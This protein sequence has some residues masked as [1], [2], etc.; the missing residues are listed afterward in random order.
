M[1]IPSRTRISDTLQIWAALRRRP[2]SPRQRLL[3]TLGNLMMFA[4]L[5]LLLYVGG[6]YV[7]NDYQR[8]AA[9]GDND[10]EVPRT[11]I[12]ASVP[13]VAPQLAQVAPKSTTTAQSSTSAPVASSLPQL[14][15]ISSAM[16]SAAQVAHV[17]TVERV[18]IPSIALDSKV[19]EVG[20]S[21]QKID[22]KLAAV[23][24]VAEY[25]IGQHH[26]SANPG[27]G[28]NIVLAGHVGGYGHVF[29]DLFYVHPGEQVIVYSAG[30]EFLYVVQERL[31]VEEDDAPLAQRIENTKLI[32]PTDHEQI[33]MITC[34]P[35]KGPDKFK[36]RV[37]IHAL[38]F[39]APVT[40]NPDTSTIR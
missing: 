4:G 17:S 36:Q 26:G 10:L 16:P 29:R 38:P 35:P 37:V 33:T 32:G 24:D 20:W 3:W 15:T 9:R 34:W 31:I 8:L 5:Y 6:I 39:S 12:S 25:A 22:G 14:G 23:W 18:V 30:Q 7:Q 19:I 27:E 21:T 40:P 1:L 28:G 2:V 11:M 13:E